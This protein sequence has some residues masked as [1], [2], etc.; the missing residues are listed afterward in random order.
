MFGLSALT[1][2]LA[3]VTQLCGVSAVPLSD[4]AREVLG[5][6][7]HRA[8]P[9]APHWVLYSDKGSAVPKAADISGYN[10]L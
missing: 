9:A 7:T 8:A 1:V 6:A 5:H 10:A 4:K 2:A 3:A